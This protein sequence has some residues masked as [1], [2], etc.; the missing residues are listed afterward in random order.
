VAAGGGLPEAGG[1]CAGAWLLTAGGGV[2]VVVGGVVSGGVVVT[3]GVVTG[4]GSSLPRD[5]FGPWPLPLP[6]PLPW[7]RLAGAAN[8]RA[9]MSTDVAT[10]MLRRRR[11]PRPWFRRIDR[12]MYMTGRAGALNVGDDTRKASSAFGLLHGA[13][14]PTSRLSTWRARRRHGHDA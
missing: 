3:G 10:P 14:E 2:A 12:G 5:G 8:P 13:A 9:R 6:L 11:G 1:G 4:G 7:A